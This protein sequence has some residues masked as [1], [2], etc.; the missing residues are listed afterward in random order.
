MVTKKYRWPVQGRISKRDFG[1]KLHPIKKAMEF[2][3]GQDISCPANTLI[4]SP[5]NGIVVMVD[6]LDDSAGGLMLKIKHSANDLNR[7]VTGYAHLESIE[8]SNGQVIK[9]GDLIAYSGNTGASTG[10]HLHFTLTNPDGE[11]IN[12]KIMFTYDID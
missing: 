6:S 5:E 1:N 4:Y 11:K 3:N 7:Y 9:K 12:P 10:P 2:H 8:V